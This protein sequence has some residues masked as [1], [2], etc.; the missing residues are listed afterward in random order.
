MRCVLLRCESGSGAS[1]GVPRSAKSDRMC[2]C[3][4][5]SASETAAFAF[6]GVCK[7]LSIEM[8]CEKR[9]PNGLLLCMVI[10]GHAKV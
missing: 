1:L 3:S 9:P 4:D 7:K 8:A 6:R 10:G 5:V 2:G